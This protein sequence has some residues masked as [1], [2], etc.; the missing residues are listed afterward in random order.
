[1]N[2]IIIET[3]L[4]RFSSPKGDKQLRNVAL[5][6]DAYRSNFVLESVRANGSEIGVI[7][8]QEWHNPH[9]SDVEL[10][11]GKRHYS[12]TIA[13]TASKHGTYR[14]N[15]IFGFKCCPVFLQRLCA[16]YLPIEDYARIQ[17]ATNYQLSQIPPRWTNP[18]EFY[19]P[20][21][22]HAN[23]REIKLSRIYPYPDKQNFF[24]TQD[25]LSDNRLTPLNY[26]G[27]MHEM[28]TVEEIARHEQ[29]SRYNQVS[30]LRLRSEYILRNNDGSTIA[31]YTPPGELF[32]Q[33]RFFLAFKTFS[34]SF[35]FFHFLA[36]FQS[37]RSYIMPRAQK[38]CRSSFCER[39]ILYINFHTSRTF[40]LSSF[41]APS[42]IT[43]VFTFSLVRSNKNPPCFSPPIIANA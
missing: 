42:F 18:Y 9:A 5:I 34:S 23:L 35:F 30:W 10:S 40:W 33:V 25:M 17:T 1:M 16:D 12:V 2:A 15:I 11:N 4:C 39:I 38:V 3:D 7:N 24:L 22:P 31:K 29:L 8:G 28:I 26:R 19:S 43:H 36:T 27:R 32:A 13:F 6:S 20:F 37:F 21:M 14:Q 41:F